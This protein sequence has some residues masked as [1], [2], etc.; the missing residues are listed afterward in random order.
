MRTKGFTKR[1][2]L[3]DVHVIVFSALSVKTRYPLLPLRNQHK[4]PAQVR[5]V[6]LTFWHAMYVVGLHKKLA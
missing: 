6:V 1:T 5:L 3:I 4:F 2:C